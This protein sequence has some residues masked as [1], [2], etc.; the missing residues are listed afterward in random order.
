[1]R[2]QCVADGQDLPEPCDWIRAVVVGIPARVFRVS[3]HNSFGDSSPHNRVEA[4]PLLRRG[5]TG[6]AL[7][8]S[9]LNGMTVVAAHT[10]HVGVGEIGRTVSTNAHQ[11]CE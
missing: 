4:C 9:P 11:G 10:L 7:A 8:V 5:A 3:P 1:M 2:Q 6:L